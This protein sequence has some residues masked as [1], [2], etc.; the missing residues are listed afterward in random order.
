M[1]RPRKCRNI[2]FYPYNTK[3]TPEKGFGE[4]I[5]L[6]FEEVESLRL[7]DLNEMDQFAAA[8]SMN[9]SRGTLQRIL[10]LARKKVADAVINGK[11]IRISQCECGKDDCECHKYSPGENHNKKRCQEKHCMMNQHDDFCPKHNKPLDKE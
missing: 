4:E 11:A 2:G 9:V 5:I 7:C 10:N 8:D 3:F 6:T 1:P